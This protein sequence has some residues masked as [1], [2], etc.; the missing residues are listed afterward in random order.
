MLALGCF[1]PFATIGIGAVLGS[2]LGSE[3]GGYWGAAAGLGAGA[4]IVAVGL[5]IFSRVRRTG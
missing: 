4:L 3:R 2:Y 5:L 1:I